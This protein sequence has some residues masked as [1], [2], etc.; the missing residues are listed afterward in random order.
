MPLI[1]AR[2]YSQ[3]G[4]AHFEVPIN[5]V[6]SIDSVLHLLHRGIKHSESSSGFC[7]EWFTAQGPTPPSPLLRREINYGT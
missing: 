2:E 4:E 3:I 5:L 6:A 7:K 1:K